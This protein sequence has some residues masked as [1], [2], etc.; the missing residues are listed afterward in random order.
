MINREQRKR[1]YE[2]QHRPE[3][4]KFLEKLAKYVGIA[5]LVPVVVL[6]L[7]NPWTWIFLLVYL[8]ISPMWKD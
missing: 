1:N 8:I 6:S 4:V 5:V 7:F 3:L 2:Y